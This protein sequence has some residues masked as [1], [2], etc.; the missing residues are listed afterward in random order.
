MRSAASFP[1]STCRVS[2]LTQKRVNHRLK[3]G[4]LCYGR[5]QRIAALTYALPSDLRYFLDFLSPIL[6]AF[7]FTVS[8]GR[9]SLAAILAVGLFGKSL[10]SRLTSV[11]DH[12]PLTALFLFA[13]AQSFQLDRA[14]ACH[15]L[16]RILTGRIAAIKP[17]FLSPVKQKTAGGRLFCLVTGPDAVTS[18]QTPIKGV[19]Q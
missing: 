4:W 9:P 13:I 12:K 8:V 18:L 16:Y 10:L 1:R 2:G 17:L 5:F 19:G 6:D 3:C 7:F 11:F 15:R 14:C